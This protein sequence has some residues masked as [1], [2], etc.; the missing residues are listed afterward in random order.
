MGAG[1]VEELYQRL[2]EMAVN[3]QFK[4]GERINEVA[5]ANDLA[6]SRTPLREALNRLVAEQFFAFIRRATD[7]PVELLRYPR[8]G[9]ELSRSGEPEHRVSRLTVM[10]EWFDRYCMPE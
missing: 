1:R 4:P 3:F 9:H 6:A 10:L 2:K 5:L 8:D 7:T